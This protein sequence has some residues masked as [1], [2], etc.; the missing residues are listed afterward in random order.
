MA[1]QPAAI[2]NDAILNGYN[3][4]RPLQTSGARPPLFCFFPGL[5]GARDLADSLPNDQP[6]YQFFYPNLDGASKFPAVEEL[7]TAY[8]RDIRRIQVHGPYQLCGYSKAGLLAYEAARLL[9]TQGE[10]V[11]FLALLE[12][13][14]PRYAQNLTLRESAQFQF[15]YAVDRIRKYCRDLKLGEFDHFVARVWEAVARRAKL[16][17]WRVVRLFYQTAIRPVPK[18]MQ[19]IESTAVLKDFVPK[20]Y[21]NRFFLFRTDD[22]FEMGLSDQT[23]GWYKCAAEGVDILFVLGDH[24]TM[25]DKPCVQSLADKIVPHLADA[26]PSHE[27]TDVNEESLG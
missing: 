7:A 4:V 5:P 2:L 17:A 22:K 15:R 12:T 10:S 1:V 21:P 11:S 24:G 23:F 26:Q 20:S 18:S 27:K 6:V 8:L 9:V 25:K 14:H 3:Y 13:W 16:A 19:T